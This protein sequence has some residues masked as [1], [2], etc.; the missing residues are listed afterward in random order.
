MNDLLILSKVLMGKYDLN[1]TNYLTCLFNNPYPSRNAPLFNVEN[2]SIENFQ[3]LLASNT[4]I[5]QTSFT[6]GKL[7]PT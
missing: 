1:W 4:K 5:G 2:S 6:L 7:P 3:K